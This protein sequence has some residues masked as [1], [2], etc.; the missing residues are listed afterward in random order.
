MLKICQQMKSS[1]RAQAAFIARGDAPDFPFHDLITTICTMCVSL[2]QCRLC[3][4]NSTTFNAGKDSILVIREADDASTC[5]F[6]VYA[7]LLSVLFSPPSNTSLSL[8]LSL[9][10]Y[11]PPS[12]RPLCTTHRRNSKTTSI[13]ENKS[14]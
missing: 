1:A 2:L 14:Q 4:R 5:E 10:F 9:S 6:R 12:P 3:T 8:S 11:L 13:T 7:S